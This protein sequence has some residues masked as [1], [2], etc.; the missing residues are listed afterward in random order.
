VLQDEPGRA[1]LQESLIARR[2]LG[3]RMPHWRAG[4]S[5]ARRS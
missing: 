3:G 2:L 4:M 5:A 1:R